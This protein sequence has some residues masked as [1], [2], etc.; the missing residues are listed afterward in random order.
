MKRTGAP[1]A[2]E[3]LLDAAEE[4]VARDGVGMLTLERVA[5]EALVSKGGLLYHF[6]SKEALIEG[7]VERQLRE[8]NDAFEMALRTEAPDPGRATRAMVRASF[9][10]ATRPKE[11]ERRTAVA[12]LAAVV[13]RPGLLDPV[14]E[15]YRRWTKQLIEDGLPAG[16]SVAVLAALDGMYFWN[17]LGINEVGP[18]QT[19]AARRALEELARVPT[20]RPPSRR[21]KR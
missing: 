19:G 2:R 8:I 17:L 11:R 5:A 4:L 18:A 12:L 20:K 6:P 21:G 16:R 1:N 14:R 10:P 3:R 7:M 13:T 9:G 15:A